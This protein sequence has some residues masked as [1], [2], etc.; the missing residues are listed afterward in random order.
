MEKEIKEIISLSYKNRFS[1]YYKPDY[2]LVRTYFKNGSQHK[3]VG[4]TVIEAI[5]KIIGFLR[6]QQKNRRINKTFQHS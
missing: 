3:E 4:K 2:C 1:I 5:T 6:S